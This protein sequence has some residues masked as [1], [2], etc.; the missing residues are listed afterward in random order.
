MSK[1]CREQTIDIKKSSFYNC[2]YYPQ[3]ILHNAF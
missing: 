2:H 1:V 3:E